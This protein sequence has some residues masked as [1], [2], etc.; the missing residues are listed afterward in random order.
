MSIYGRIAPWYDALFPV[1]EA[2]AAFFQRLLREAHCRSVLDVGCGTGRHL[3]LFA[4]WGLTVGGLE[5]EAEMAAKAAERLADAGLRAELAVCGLE[6]ALEAF[7]KAYDAAVCLG[8]TLAHLDTPSRL[9][10]GL[11]VL[12]RL[13]KPWGLL[14]TQTVN[15]DAVLREGRSAFPERRIE[16]PE[17]GP[18][19]FRRRYLF[20]GA[21]ERLLFRLELTGEALHLR[22]EIPLRPYSCQDQKVLIESCGFRIEQTYGDWDGSA[23]AADSPAIILVARRSR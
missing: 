15:F 22:E 12:A 9:V 17:E 3:E 4:G 14:V 19:V 10:A 6:E 8:N 20:D 18:L 1:G 23:H 21:P 7:P 16:D 13:L 5:P 11:N 2:Q